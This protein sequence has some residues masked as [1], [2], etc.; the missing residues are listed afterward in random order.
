MQCQ[1]WRCCIDSVKFFL[2]QEQWNGIQKAVVLGLSFFTHYRCKYRQITSALWTLAFPRAM[3]REWIGC[4]VCWQESETALRVASLCVGCWWGCGP[5][6]SVYQDR[7]SCP[8]PIT[9]SQALTDSPGQGSWHRLTEE[10]LQSL[11]ILIKS[12]FME[13]EAGR[14]LWKVM[15]HMVSRPLGAHVLTHGPFPKTLSQTGQCQSSHPSLNG[16]RG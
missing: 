12:R 4:L 6:S 14:G 2:V 9:S 8:P 11:P 7:C 1:P 10:H 15:E 3:R 16:E 13:C 5:S